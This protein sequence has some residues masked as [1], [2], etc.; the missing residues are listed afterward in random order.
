MRIGFGGWQTGGH[1]WGQTDNET[2]MDSI[3]LAYE[4]GVR[5]FD[6]ADVYGLGKSEEIISAALG[7]NKTN[8]EIATKGGVRFTKDGNRW[9]DSSPEYLRLAAEQS[10][11]RM[12]VSA[13]SLYYLHWPPENGLTDESLDAVADI[14]RRGYAEKVGVCNVAL[15][16]IEKI[17]KYNEISVVQIRLN[18]LNWSPGLQIAS[19]ARAHGLEVISHSSLE[20][21]ILS[22]SVTPQTLFDKGDVRKRNAFLDPD[23]WAQTQLLVDGL[24]ALA[25]TCGSSPTK[26]A[27]N[28][29]L[30]IAKVSYALVGIKTPD[31]I[32]EAVN[33]EQSHISEEQ[34]SNLTELTRRAFP[35]D[36]T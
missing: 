21:G 25:K 5:H 20:Q 7:E 26:V 22:G 30:K 3:R 36:E 31:Q 9:I 28:W 32:R 1:G 35:A 17:K 4:L 2:P 19:I 27:L 11:R 29:L 24:T 23:K 34:L 6:T 16:D 33:S 14:A 13:I 18:L 15:T 12:R 10:I 8:V